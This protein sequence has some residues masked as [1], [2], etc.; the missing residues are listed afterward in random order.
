[1]QVAQRCITG[2][3]GDPQIH[4]TGPALAGLALQ[5]GRQQHAYPGA[6]GTE[7]C[8]AQLGG[9][10]KVHRHLPDA[11]GLKPARNAQCLRAPLGERQ[12]W[13]G[14]QQSIRGGVEQQVFKIQP[15]HAIH[16][17]GRP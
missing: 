15:V 11:T 10:F 7:Q 12:R 6:P 13:R 14:G 9:I 16:F 1:M 5:V 4:L 8:D 2:L 3:V 17:M